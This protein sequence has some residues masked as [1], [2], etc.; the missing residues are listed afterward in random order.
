MAY[1]V[2]SVQVYQDLL[3]TG[4]VLNSTP[5]LEACIIGP[6]YNVLSY[7]PGNTSSQIK[8][9]ALSTAS[10]TG[11]MESLNP[12]LTVV[13]TGGFNVGDV[14]IVDG[15]GESGAPLQA[16]ILDISGNILT[17]DLVAG[18]TVTNATVSKSAKI[19]D[20]T[21]ANTFK[22]PGVRPGQVINSSSIKPW[23]N[24]AR[25]Q[26][27]I[28]GCETYYSSSLLTVLTPSTTGNITSGQQTLT[29]TTSRGFV[30]GDYLTVVGAGAAG[31]TL[32]AK[33]SNI[34]GNTLTVTPAAGTTVTGAAVAKVVPTNLNSTTNT[35][36]VE[37]G[38]EVIVTYTNTSAVISTLTTQ[39]RSLVT[40]SG[41]NGT[42][43]TIT[44][45]DMM[46]SLMSNQTTGSITSG[47]G[48]LTVGANTG[49]ANGVRV[50]VRGAGA[51]G[52][53]LVATI[54]NVS[55]TNIT[56]DTNAGTTVAGAQ[57][58]VIANTSVSFIKT[59]NN[60]QMPA[61]RPIT[62]GANFDTTNAGTLNEVTINSGSELVY[63]SVVSGDVFFS[64]SALRTDLSGTVLTINDV[65]DL[66]GQL[67]E[68]TDENPLALGC[69][70]ALANTV[71]RV[72]AIA[73]DSNDLTGYLDALT[74][75][76]GE[77][78][79][80]LT[81]LTQDVAILAAFKAHVEQMSTPE[82]ASWRVAV[83]NTAIPTTQ[84]VGQYSSSFVNANSGNN[85]VTLVTGKYVLTASN[86]T[87]ISD[88]VVP[89]DLVNFTAAT[90]SGQIGAHQILEV[91]SNQQLVISTTATS[92]A[93]S[94]YVSRSMTKTQSA[95]A[96]KAA[97]EVFGSN[98][99][100]HIQPDTVGVSIQGVTKYLPG[101]Y[102]CC[103]LAGMVAGFPVQQGFTN[104][105]V[106][107]IV[108]LKNSNFYFSKAELGT[109]A[110]GGTCLFVQETQSGIPYCRHE[111]T[112][113]VTVLE[114]REI[115]VVKNWDY[116]SYFY[117]DKL[118]GFIGRYNITNDTIN[119]IRQTII[120][121][122]ELVKSKKLP[123]IGAPLLGYNIT[124]LE[125]NAFNKDNLDCYMAISVVYPLNYL[126]LHLVI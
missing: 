92:T 46:P 52:A 39:V 60:Q 62:G 90:P 113:D 43:T 20:S 45:N 88:G 106:A 19:L 122:S 16:T 123:K 50:L 40:S 78:L 93:V 80:A 18:T 30:I 85:T 57:V 59:Y 11:S 3:N 37:P 87:F 117:Y 13:S 74:V 103:G 73:I 5:D 21:I 53:D 2:P 22:L 69:S 76:E 51:S 110:E 35:L 84:T 26:T 54:T 94:Y 68:S 115:L 12:E 44:V 97:S 104:I 64:Y 27:L 125:Q 49:M 32:T 77:R 124:K 114:Y 38:D 4:G 126:N 56:L 14:V 48:A 65:D 81:P 66:E 55:G 79:Y 61:T 119:L 33:I 70:L 95:E 63:G 10:T 98:R 105:G 112:T 99:V 58:I 101:Y 107:G 15:A 29:V 109:M 17:L 25:I 121:A 100:W 83:V 6:A 31:A 23:L 42:I 9:A 72:R 36:K 71:G 118:K 41:L 24:N 47:T 102:L 8:T 120:A 86:A 34:V 82:N 108:D 75:A 96:V 7:V 1:I 67:G 116:L 91:V 111:L 28:T 89:G